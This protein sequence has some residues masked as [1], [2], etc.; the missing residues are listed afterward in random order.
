MTGIGLGPD[1]GF[2]YSQTESQQRIINTTF[3]A[4]SSRANDRLDN[5]EPLEGMVLDFAGEV[6]VTGN[7]GLANAL[8]NALR[9]YVPIASMIAGGFLTLLSGAEYIGAIPCSWLP[10]LTAA[11]L[12]LGL[13]APLVVR[14]LTARP[15][16]AGSADPLSEKTAVEPE[17]YDDA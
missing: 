10:A 2:D 7:T 6:Q 15:Q 17:S 5:A 12:G 3:G 9:N 8:Q 13:V 1:N 4:G 11:S 14:K 16:T